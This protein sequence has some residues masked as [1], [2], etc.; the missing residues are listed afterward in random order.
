MGQLE[1][2]EQSETSFQKSERLRGEIVS[3]SSAQIQKALSNGNLKEFL[4][5]EKNITIAN[6]ENF[7]WIFNLEPK[8]SKDDFFSDKMYGNDENIKSKEE[9]FCKE[10][11]Q[12]LKNIKV[13]DIKNVPI[14]L[15]R[16]RIGDDWKY[17]VLAHFPKGTKIIDPK[18]DNY[19]I[20]DSEDGFLYYHATVACA[21]HA[22]DIL[23]KRMKE[24][25]NDYIVLP[26]ISPEEFWSGENGPV[27]GVIEFKDPETGELRKAE[28]EV[29]RALV[30]C[31][32]N[33]KYRYRIPINLLNEK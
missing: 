7:E 18:Y 16:F 8:Y 31:Y 24:E 29:M 30:G 23:Y 6:D 15:R 21:N 19:D 17:R 13:S 22:C 33:L 10:M 27:S 3:E 25:G 32:T 28:T 11:Y 12:S 20:K 1:Q 2:L 5:A 14:S 26:Y 4:Q 9:K